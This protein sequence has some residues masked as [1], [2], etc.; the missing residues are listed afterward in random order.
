MGW[1]FIRQ[2]TEDLSVKC[3]QGRRPSLPRAHPT[4]ANRQSACVCKALRHPRALSRFAK[5]RAPSA[6][7]GF[8]LNRRREGLV[9]GM[10]E[11]KAGEA[12]GL[13]G[14]LALSL[15]PALDT[16]AHRLCR[17]WTFVQEDQQPCGN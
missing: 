14:H 3:S 13:C 10:P 4:G 15:G 5:G 16:S 12:T 8:W 6:L 11:A 7:R 1:D 17:R 2:A 9:S